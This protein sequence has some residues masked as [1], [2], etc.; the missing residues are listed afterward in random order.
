MC[1]LEYVT[2]LIFCLKDLSTDVGGVLKVSYYYCIAF[3]STSPLC[4]CLFYVFRCSYIE[5][6]YV[7]K[8][9]ILFLYWFFYYYIVFFFMAFVLKSVLSDMS[10]AVPTSL[11]FPFTWSIFFH[12]LTFSLCV[13]FTLQW[14]SC[15][16]H[17][18]SFYYP[19]CHSM[20][21]DRI[22]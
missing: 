19:T 22:S 12:L 18:V 11:S 16:Q 7:S 4:L 14:I 13:F 2:L 10:I 8:C 15:R 5:C 1:H 3:L 20:S 21:F 17:T 9:N 6:I